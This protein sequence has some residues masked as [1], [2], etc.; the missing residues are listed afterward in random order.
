[1]LNKKNAVDPINE[2]FKKMLLMLNSKIVRTVYK[3]FQKKKQKQYTKL[4]K[5]DNL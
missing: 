1:M 3:I 4:K 5:I 2:C